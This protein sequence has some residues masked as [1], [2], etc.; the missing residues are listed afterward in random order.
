MRFESSDRP[1]PHQQPDSQPYT[2]Y[3][4][5]LGIPSRQQ[6]ERWTPPGVPKSERPAVILR[7]AA[8]RETPAAPYT[9]P[10]EWIELRDAYLNRYH[11]KNTDGLDIDR[12]N[13]FTSQ[14]GLEAA[15]RIFVTPDDLDNVHQMEKYGVLKNILKRGGLGVFSQEM[16]L[17][18]IK[19]DPR[20]EAHNGPLFTE[21]IAVHEDRHATAIRVPHIENDNGFKFV[22]V[23]GQS[24]VEGDKVFGQLLEE[25]ECDFYRAQYMTQHAGAGSLAMV[26]EY[27]GLPQGHPIESTIMYTNEGKPTPLPIKY[28]GIKP[29]GS[30]GA[31]TASLA[32]FAVELLIEADPRIKDALRSVR[33]DKTKLPDLAEKIN[34]LRSRLYPRLNEIQYTAPDIMRGLQTVIRK[35]SGGTNKVIRRRAP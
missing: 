3:P 23:V 32:G 8:P 18:I 5:P 16:G 13:D 11:G 33:T 4:G 31:A 27:L 1:D 9:P 28:I 26:L 30:L 25:G 21:G 19:R 17:T 6:A 20:I 15:P 10:P 12:V 14:Q 2:G 34:A 29:N 22:P 7:P 24:V 35:V